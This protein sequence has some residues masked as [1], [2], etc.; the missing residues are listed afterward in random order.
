MGAGELCSP[1]LLGGWGAKLA[2]VVVK[3]FRLWWVGG[4]RDVFIGEV[5]SHIPLFCTN[6]ALVLT[7]AFHNT[8]LPPPS[9]ITTTTA[10]AALP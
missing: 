3:L 10:F 8:S 6:P 5:S 2:V 4:A 7:C 9:K 1:I